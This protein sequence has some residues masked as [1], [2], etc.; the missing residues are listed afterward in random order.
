[1]ILIF[2][3]TGVKKKKKSRGLI[4]RLERSERER[5]S[6]SRTREIRCLIN[7]LRA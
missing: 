7:N 3:V 6:E 5:G 4:V 2:N 1:M